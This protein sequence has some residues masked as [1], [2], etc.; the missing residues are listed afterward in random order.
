MGEPEEIADAV[1]FFASDM[2]KY[3]TGQILGV[4]GSISL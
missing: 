3:T 2:S 1:L 4:H